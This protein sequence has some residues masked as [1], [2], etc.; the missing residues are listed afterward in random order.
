MPSKWLVLLSMQ[1]ALA[2]LCLCKPSPVP[3]EVSDEET[4]VFAFSG[5]KSQVAR[6]ESTLPKLKPVLHTSG[7]WIRSQVFERGEYI[8]VWWHFSLCHVS[9]ASVWPTWAGGGFPCS[10]PDGGRSSGSFQSQ[11]GRRRG[12]SRTCLQGLLPCSAHLD[13]QVLKGR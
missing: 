12:Q 8:K 3:R 11:G 1:P 6:P 7:L 5:C 10:S 13:V 2:E 9:Q 4:R